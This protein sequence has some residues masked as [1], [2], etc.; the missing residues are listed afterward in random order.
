[1]VVAAIGSAPVKTLLLQPA[2]AVQWTLVVPDLLTAEALADGGSAA[3]QQLAG[4]V[5]D[6]VR[7]GR[8]QAARDLLAAAPPE[9]A[10]VHGRSLLD[11][12]LALHEGRPADARGQLEALVAQAPQQAAGWRLLALAALVLDD[13]PRAA[14]AATRA[15]EL[16]PEQPDGWVL[17]GYVAQARFDLDRAVDHVRR[18]LQVEPAHVTALVALAR[19]RFGQGY[20]AEARGLAERAVALAPGNG[21]ALNL[22]GFVALGG[23]DTAVAA[24]RFADA[25]EHAP[26]LAEPYL[27]LGL[28]WLR[29]GEVLAGLEALSNA[30]LLEPRRALLRTYWAKGLYEV[31]LQQKALD[32]LEVSR[33]IDPRDPSPHFY[34]AL[35]LRDLRQPDAAIAA[36]QAAQALNGN[37]GV[38]RSRFLLDQD[39][40]V[41]NVDLSLL[42]AELGLAA[43][44]RRGAVDAVAEDYAN[45]SAHLQYA[46]SLNGQ[47]DRSWARNTENLLARLLQPANINTFNSFNEYTTFVEKPGYGATAELSVGEH[48]TR[49]GQ[50]LA[51]GADPGRGL[52]VGV[53]GIRRQT[54]GWRDTDFERVGDIVGY[55]KWDPSADHGLMLA[56]SGSDSELGDRLLP[57]YEHSAPS[58]PRDRTDGRTRRLEVG[59][60]RRFGPGNDL[61]MHASR[62]DLE[63]DQRSVLELCTPGVTAVCDQFNPPPQD[64]EQWADLALEQPY[65]LLQGAW[66]RRHDAHGLVLGAAWYDGEQE[67]LAAFDN[68]VG[69]P[70]NQVLPVVVTPPGRE[71]DRRSLSL[72][73]HDLWRPRPGLL[74]HAGLH[75][76]SMD[77]RDVDLQRGLAATQLRDA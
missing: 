43:W 27:G 32:V 36:L 12:W 28:A 20:T 46:G 61:L 25:I 77:N 19:L 66:L 26:G 62:L 2:D 11:A 35:V 10:A 24:E 15:T 14:E 9:P 42:Y 29:Q 67:L 8:L 3:L 13:K 58:E 73:L 45:A 56:A 53:G 30:V 72:W 22:L 74:V 55:L 47:P 71:R 4:Q 52:A 38:Y 39:S 54:D 34:R 37:R 69:P 57:R 70:Y 41:R 60:H 31:G 76:E 64:W 59:Y 49:E 40:A 65:T 7:G 68:L 51:Y 50:L 63:L 33:E 1:Q 23:G 5:V 44:S 18:A 6:A 75:Y 48:G 21:E 17:R 16:A